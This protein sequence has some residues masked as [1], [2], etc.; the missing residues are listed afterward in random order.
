MAMKQ[1]SK[2]PAPL[3]VLAALVVATSFCGWSAVPGLAAPNPFDVTVKPLDIG[4]PLPR[5]ALV[6]QHGRPVDMSAMRG[7]TIVLGFIYTSC[8]DACPIITAKFGRLDE[9]LGP[10]PYR[11]L[12]MTIDPVHD[13]Q[14]ALAS[15][16]R[17][18][19]V[20]S[21]RWQLV[22]G[23]PAQV[24]QFV[25]SAGVSV[26]DN[27]RGELV[28]STRLLL[29]GPDGR[30]SD[31]VDVAAWDPGDVAARMQ[32][33]AGRRS[34]P[35]AQADFALTKTIAQFCGGSYQVASGIMD[36]VAVILLVGIS[37]WIALWM[38][39]RLFEQGA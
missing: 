36:V 35:L 17:T 31:I 14:A 10:G 9:T 29:V 18:H 12:E 7:D 13:T 2:A 28:H 30:L 27:G 32:G 6:D 3:V 39:R 19:A 1:K 26:V 22:T 20:R 4:D 15:Y 16:A 11:L 25:R 38:R 34:S 21:G 8:K 5:V 37:T 33:L 24:D 23:R